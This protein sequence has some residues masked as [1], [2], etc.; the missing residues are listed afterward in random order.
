[1]SLYLRLTAL[2][3][4]TQRCEKLA[5]QHTHLKTQLAGELRCVCLLQCVC[6]C[7]RGDGF[8]CNLMI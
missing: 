1:M 3:T 6:V 4:N 2:H 5:D 8:L 7:R